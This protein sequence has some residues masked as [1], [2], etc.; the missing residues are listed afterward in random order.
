[1]PGQP[2]STGRPWVEIA[3]RT[4]NHVLEQWDETIC[5]GGIYWSRNRQSTNLGQRYYKS[6]VTNG[7]A[8]EVAAR[9]YDLTKNATY[10]EWADKIYAWMKNKVIMPDN[11]VIDGF[12]ADDPNDCGMPK[13]TLDVVRIS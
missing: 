8:I 10:V 13:A 3:D 2:F 7:Q 11:S 4:F 9:L 5:E 6:S 1:L 12:H